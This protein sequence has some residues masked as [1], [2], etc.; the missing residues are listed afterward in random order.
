MEKE[1]ATSP[2]E[3]AALETIRN[4]CQGTANRSQAARFLEAWSRFPVT[5]FGALRH[6]NVYCCSARALQLRKKGCRIAARGQTVATEA[7][8]K[9]RAGPSLLKGRQ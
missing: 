1:K 7:G 6:L 8:E 3:K 2:E 4:E 9:H 5:A